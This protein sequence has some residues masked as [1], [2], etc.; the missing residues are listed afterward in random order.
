MDI[1]VK[2]IIL[3]RFRSFLADHVDLDN[4]TFLV[5][6]NGSGKSNFADVFSFLSDAMSSPLKAVFDKRAGISSV[7]NRTSGIGY[8]S[9]MGI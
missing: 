2:K 1:S 3:K 9:N 8:P 7:R 4:P 5:G 6:K